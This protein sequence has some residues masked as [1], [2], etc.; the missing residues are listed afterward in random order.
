MA[1]W[2]GWIVTEKGLSLQAKVEAGAVMNFTKIKT[3]DGLIGDQAIEKLTDVLQPKQNL[4]I[5]SVAAL[6]N[7]QCRLT[8]VVTNKGITAGYYM[9]ELGIFAED[10]NL[11]EI[12]FAYN[13]DP[14][15]DY[16]PAEG[17]ATVVGQEFEIYIAVSNNA[18]IQ[19]HLDMSSLASQGD[20][21][22]AIK[23]YVQVLDK[24]G[25]DT[26]M[27]LAIRFTED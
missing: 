12:L 24:N 27:K 3:G 10:P 5:G 22:N 15:P 4:G 19:A 2:S 16:L 7:G 11:G 14:A 13:Y 23:K 20:V 8:S 21:L 25:N 1:N 18:I 6:D 17:G 9:R 26:D